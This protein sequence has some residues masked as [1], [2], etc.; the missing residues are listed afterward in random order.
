MGAFPALC[1]TRQSL[2]AAY[3]GVAVLSRSFVTAAAVEASRLQYTA[4]RNSQARFSKC[5]SRFHVRRI[6]SLSRYYP[7]DIAVAQEQMLRGIAYLCSSLCDSGSALTTEK[8]TSGADS[9]MRLDLLW[10]CTLNQRLEWRRQSSREVAM[11]TTDE[12]TG[13]RCQEQRM[14]CHGTR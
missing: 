4:E 3:R 11:R 6:P 9:R 12:A 1:S 10:V 2:T 5:V 7:R 13:K 8:W 14:S